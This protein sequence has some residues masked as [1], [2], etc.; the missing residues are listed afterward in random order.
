MLERPSP[1]PRV[2]GGERA[3]AQGGRLRRQPQRARV[4]KTLF[5]GRQDWTRGGLGIDDAIGVQ[6][7]RK[8]RGEEVTA[9]QAPQNRTFQAGED[10]GREQS[11]AC[12]CSLAAPAS[13]N[14]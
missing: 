1:R 3:S 7:E 14:S 2:E 6:A 11:S 8:G 4:P 5:N 10:A 13:M 9:L 12:A